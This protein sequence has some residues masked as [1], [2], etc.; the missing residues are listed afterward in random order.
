[1]IDRTMKA[2]T[3]EREIEERVSPP[4]MVVY[5]AIYREG[6]HELGRP[7]GALALSGLA[8]G[9]SMGFS[10][11]SEGFLIPLLPRA[12]WAPAVSKLGYTIGFLV[13]ILGR[14][15]LFSKNT[16]TVILPAL[17]R[18]GPALRR[19]QI[20]GR[21]W[22]IILGGNLVGAALFA[23]FMAMPNIFS[24]DVQHALR[25]IVGQEMEGAFFSIFA[26]SVL[27]GWL[28]ALM[29][30][31]LPFAEAGRLW[32]VIILAYV[33]GIGRLPHVVAGSVGMF[34]GILTGSQP[35][36]RSLIHFLLPAFLGNAIGGVALVAVGAHAEFVQQGSSKT[37]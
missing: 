33:V 30:W 9:L 34:Y 10:F 2:T 4:G 21:L 20:V 29:I 7:A 3:K 31:L 17:R 5:E 28:I 18:P 32:L 1:M 11:L 25:T 36:G 6:E 13:V 27:A 15:Q 8:A 19:M 35:L 14:Q 24:G 12:H 26:R 37:R 16:L 22:A 23:A